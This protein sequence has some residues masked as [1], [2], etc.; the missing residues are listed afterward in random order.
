MALAVALLAAACS[1]GG[2]SG[3]SGGD[4]LDPRELSGDWQVT[5]VIGTAD[6]DPDINQALVPDRTIDYD[7][8]WRFES[9]DDTG[10]TLRRPDGGL[11]LGD[12]DNVRVSLPDGASGDR[13]ELE[14][15]TDAAEP[16]SEGT[17][18][19]PCEGAVTDHWTVSL[20]VGTHDRVLSGSVLRNADEHRTE[21]DGTPCW[22][23]DLSLGFS[24][25]PL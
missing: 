12:L 21:V 8:H 24:G 1:D 9:C 7:E 6:F 25:V 23:V 16:L 20:R 22:G 3:G 19:G 17:P 4:T 15:E 11:L 18:A 13:V 2:G 10:C 14:A 5:L